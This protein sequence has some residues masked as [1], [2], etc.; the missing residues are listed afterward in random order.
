MEF[1]SQESTG[2]VV[3][4]KDGIVATL[5]FR[6][7]VSADAAECIA[8]RG[9]TRENAISAATLASMGITTGSWGNSIET[10]RLP[11]YLCTDE[12]TVV[13]YCFGDKD[14]GEI[15]VLAVLPHYEG[16]GIGKALLSQ[17]VEDLR[18]LGYRRLFLG[19]SSDSSHR[20]YGFYRHLGWRSTGSFDTNDDEVLEL[21]WQDSTHED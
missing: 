10:G 11:G 18:S 17:V 15:V 8:L 4:V 2:G 6:R 21:R 16:R 13:G 5:Q 12:N 3:R 1:S 20:S 9:R 7:A 19:C 14:S